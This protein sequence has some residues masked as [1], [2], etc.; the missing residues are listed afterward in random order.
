MRRVVVFFSVAALSLVSFS[1]L[2]FMTDGC[3]SG[4]CSDCH[5]LTQKEAEA[6]LGKLVDKVLGVR[7]AAVPGMWEVD[8]EKRGQKLPVFLD[9][10]KRFVITGDVIDLEKM[11]SVTRER[12][13]DLNRIDP[14]VIPLEDAVV[15]GD[16]E[17]PTRIVVFD[18]PECPFCKKLHPEMKKVVQKRPDVAFF[19]KMLPLKIHPNARKKAQAIICAKSAQMLEDSLAG[20]PIPDPTCET[21]QIEKNE[22]L[23]KQIGVRSTPTLVFPDGRVVPGYKDAATILSYLDT[24]ETGGKKEAAKH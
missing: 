4:K 23:A 10:S 5:T 24:P 19:I 18:D 17:A 20:K 21:D 2:A 22:A 9:Y 16:P 15:I 14:S 3:G 11:T 1:A 8:V 6:A 7:E 13:I 12:Y